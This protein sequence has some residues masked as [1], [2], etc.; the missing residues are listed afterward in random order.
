MHARLFMT[1]AESRIGCPGGAR[2]PCFSTVLLSKH[3]Q[4]TRGTSARTLVSGLASTGVV[5]HAE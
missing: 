4:I 2:Y 1:K 5:D 3:H